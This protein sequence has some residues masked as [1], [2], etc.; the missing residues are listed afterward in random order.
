MTILDILKDKTVSELRRIA[1]GIGCTGCSKLKKAE[2][3]EKVAGRL[4]EPETIRQVLLVMDED[5]FKR[6]KKKRRHPEGAEQ[7][8][9]TFDVQGY[10]RSILPDGDFLPHTVLS[11]EIRDFPVETLDKAFYKERK[12][13]QKLNRWLRAFTGFYGIIEAEAAVRLLKQY[14][15]ISCTADELENTAHRLAMANNHF[16]VSN[17]LII[18]EALDDE[19]EVDAL[20]QKQQGKPYTAYPKAL[21]FRFADIQYFP[22][23]PQMEPVE[24]FMRDYFHLSEKQAREETECICSILQGE[25]GPGE[26]FNVLAVD[27]L[28]FLRQED[29]EAFM[30]VFA[31]LYNNIPLWANRGATP[32]E[33]YDNQH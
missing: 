19:A 5:E 24:R 28:T 8:F 6:Y 3:A 31:P 21:M 22:R 12:E 14:E 29:V 10:G 23:L 7:L 13:L 15:G 32:A 11:D 4:A 20:W 30:E 17:R 25:M 33:M 9:P 26:V 2:L 18:H 27:G 1:A 16:W